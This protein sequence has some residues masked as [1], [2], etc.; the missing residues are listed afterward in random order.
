MRRHV[1]LDFLTEWIR[2]TAVLVFDPN[3]LA[4]A[5][6]RK[7]DIACEEKGLAFAAA[8]LVV[9]LALFETLQRHTGLWGLRR[10]AI[11]FALAEICLWSL[12]AL[13]TAGALKILKGE[14]TLINNVSVAIR[15]LSFFYIVG[16]LLGSILYKESGNN[17]YILGIG[18]ITGYCFL[19]VIC[20]PAVL[21]GL[22]QLNGRAGSLF[23]LVNLIVAAT[24]AFTSVA[25]AHRF[26]DP[27]RGMV[28]DTQKQFSALR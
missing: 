11:P 15:L 17:V 6:N 27:A 1:T 3:A 19:Q 28:L 12:Y 23:I 25:I 22:N 13:A 21:I 5:G 7:A 26:G 9:A 2:S 4:T 8:S 20:F 18:C 16:T 10:N 24:G 14:K